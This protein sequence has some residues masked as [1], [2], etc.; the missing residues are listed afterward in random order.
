MGGSMFG[1]FFEEVA[2]LFAELDVVLMPGE[3]EADALEAN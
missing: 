2:D 3:E 1:A